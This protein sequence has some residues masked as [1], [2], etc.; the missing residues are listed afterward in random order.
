MSDDV[1]WKNE[2]LGAAKRVAYY[3]ANEVGEGENFD[4]STLRE[5]IPKVTQLDRRMRDLRKVGW[6]IRSYKDLGE[7]KPNELKLEKIGEHVWE[8][9]FKWPEQGLNAKTRRLVFERDGSRCYVCG[10]EFGSPYPHAPN[11]VARGTVGHIIA[12]ERGGGDDLENLRPECHLCNEQAK[13]LTGSPVDVGLLE[14]NIRQLPRA[15]KKEL[16]KWMVAE[17]RQFSKAENLW[18]EYQQLPTSQKEKVKSELL[19]QI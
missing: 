9:G 14:R 17:R 15:D 7:L 3:L 19:T 1:I 12:R 2:N 11:V 8:D 5:Q 10:I 13:N 18:I 4:V 6:V 16:L